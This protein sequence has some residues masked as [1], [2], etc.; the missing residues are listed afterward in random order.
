MIIA[1]N[2]NIMKD[3]YS[4][5]VTL[6]CITCGDTSLEYSEDKTSI[7][8]ERC[9]REYHGGYD[10]VVALNQPEID[11]EVEKLAKEAIEDGKT[12]FKK[13]LKGIN[14]KLK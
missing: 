14:K 11:R 1:N 3:N 8:C 7:V 9:G 10:E 5:S 2:S 12:D 6:K 4:K 13:M